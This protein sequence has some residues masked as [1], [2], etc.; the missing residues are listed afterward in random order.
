MKGTA[1]DQLLAMR[2]FVRVVETASFSRAADQLALPRSTMSKLITDLERHLGI[3]LMHRTTRTVAATSEG[4]EYYNRAVH[5]I[6]EIDAVDNAVRGKRLKPSGHLRIDA[7]TSFASSLLIP[8]L[9]DF[10]REY[11]DVTVALGISDRTVNIV[12][13][14]VDCAIRAG[15][16]H[17]MTM[18][19]RKIAELQYVTCASPSYLRQMGMPISPTDLKENHVHAGYF[20]ATTGKSEPLIF[21][22]GDDRYEMDNRK[23]STNEGNGLTELMLAGLGIGQHLRRFVQPH[24]D[25]GKLVAVLEDWSR[26]AILFH[27]IYPS[28]RHQSA[29]LK[30][31]VDWLM[32]AFRETPP[33]N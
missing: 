33:V 10:H 23:F 16:L 14:G 15:E 19:G 3:K 30:V 28:N 29:R 24:L 9:P 12:G 13:E 22:K 21:E 8:S 18:I 20:F 25:S 2:A 17:D 32:N 6:G 11:P 31:F 27:V 4:L 1:V 5:L 26:P 7:P